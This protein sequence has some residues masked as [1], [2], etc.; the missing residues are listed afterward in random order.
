MV[1]QNLW[2]TFNPSVLVVGGPTCVRY[3]A[4]VEVA[5]QSLQAYADSA[6]MA[7]PTLRAA[8]FGLLASAVGA[9]ALVLHHALRPMHERSPAPGMSATR[10]ADS[11]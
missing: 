10:A 8:R 4:I 1:L 11:L 5:Q 2:T 6:G 9:A 7:T 3:P